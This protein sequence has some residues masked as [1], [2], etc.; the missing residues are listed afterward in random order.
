MRYKDFAAYINPFVCH[1]VKFLN[2][3]ACVCEEVGILRPRRNINS[4]LE[5][6]LSAQGRYFFSCHICTLRKTTLILPPHTQCCIFPV[7]FPSFVCLNG[8]CLH[9]KHIDTIV[10]LIY[11]NPWKT[12]N[13]TNPSYCSKLVIFLW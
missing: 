6:L 2:R 4:R 1:T 10:A 12:S 11:T 9:T 5:N 7:Y 13:N 8:H 3:F